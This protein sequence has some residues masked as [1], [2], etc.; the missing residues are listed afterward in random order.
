[1]FLFL[2]EDALTELHCIVQ[3]MS[4]QQKL[5]KRIISQ[6]YIWILPNMSKLVKV[7]G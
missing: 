1:M 5:K 4:A 6:I 2:P 7:Y 3:T